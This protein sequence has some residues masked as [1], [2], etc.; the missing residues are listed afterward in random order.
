MKDNILLITNVLPCDKYSGGIMSKQLVKI[1]LNEK[2]NVYCARVN[3][4]SLNE[5]VGQI[6]EQNL[7]ILDLSYSK[8]RTKEISEIV[9]RLK[10]YILKNKINKIWVTL[11]G[12]LLVNIIYQLQADVNIPFYIQIWDPIEWILKEEGVKESEKNEVLKK[13]DSIIKKSTYIFAASKPMADCYIKEYNKEACE[14]YISMDKQKFTEFSKNKND[15]NIVFSGQTYAQNEISQ[16]VKA[17]SRL[18]WKYHGKKIIFNYLGSNSL[19][20]LNEKDLKHVKIWGYVSQKKLMDICYNSDLLY[21]PYFF[22]NDISFE[23]VSKYSFPS[24]IVTYMITKT[25]IVI[26]APKYS[27]VCKLLNSISSMFINS[28]DS[29]EIYNRLINILDYIDD[30]NNRKKLA[31]DMNEIYNKNFIPECVRN[32]FLKGLGIKH[33]KNRPINIL[34]ANYT[35]ISGK[36]FNGYDIKNYLNDNTQ[37][38]SSQIVTYK[39]SND[40][41]VYR[42]YNNF[43]QEMEYKLMEFEADELSVHS[44]LSLFSPALI[45]SEVYNDCDILH[46][47]M[48]HNMKMSLFSLIKISSQK[49]VVLTIHDPWTITGRC[50]HYY[51]CNKYLTGC[52]NCPNLTSL[53]PLKKDNCHSLWKLKKMV[54]SKINPTVV[55]SSQYM[56]DLIKNSPLTSNWNKIH[57]IP[58]G[59][60]LNVFNDSLKV[61]DARKKLNINEEDFVIF[62]RSQDNFKGTKY[63]I[64]ALNKLETTKK[65]TII[66]CSEKGNLNNLYS[67]FNVIELGNADTKELIY[68][69]R[70]CDIFLMP[71]LGESFG[72]MAVEAMA[73]GKP[74]V[75]FD[76]TSL[77]SITSAPEIGVLVKNRDSDELMK[78]ISN[79]IENDEER[80][81]RGELS[82]KYAIENYNVDYHNKAM[83]SLYEKIYNDEESNDIKMS[84]N[85]NDNASENNIKI[86]LNKLLDS[87]FSK[88]TDIYSKMF[89]KKTKTFKNAEIDYSNENVQ[90]I[91][92][93]FNCNLYDIIHENFNNKQLIRK[94][95]PLR[96]IIKGF[97]LLITD[98]KKLKNIL[99]YEFHRILK[100]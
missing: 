48:I 24:K 68:A 31:T 69:Y 12:K 35:D 41:N 23:K 16:F 71:S 13:Y 38:I 84:V 67:L 7:N 14:I 34:Q 25:P 51:D 70:A 92:D 11:Q 36:R 59:V 60:D 56:Y 98:R 72:M 37:N 43:E 22:S 8:Y 4:F 97:Y 66:T 26:H 99:K 45:K 90:N 50:V 1:L 40:K 27:S 28:M 46:L 82:K 81:R 9:V 93:E 15:I 96:W 53:F 17:L 85:K 74:V 80:L 88:N 65:I 19:D 63:I 57:L 32:N 3:E 18:G 77:P 86:K 29:E 100:K 94:I 64:E 30:E 21:C 55:V 49:K 89:Y 76:N 83:S 20:F 62:F 78:A 75:V 79:L 61:E 44:N 42:I 91:I 47:H 73:C 5:D 54:Y 33:N 39:N 2:A 58:F 52:K 6:L 95:K 87:I 10:K